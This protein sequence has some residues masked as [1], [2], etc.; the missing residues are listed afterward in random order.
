VQP[1]RD[2][3]IHLNEIGISILEYLSMGTAVTGICWLLARRR[4]SQ[5]AGSA[6]KPVWVTWGAEL[7]V[8]FALVLGGRV[9]LADWPKVPSGS[10]EPTLRVGDYLLVNK[11]AYG[12]R[13][14]FTNT[15]IELEQPQRGDVVVFRYPGDVSQLYVKRLIGLPGDVVN[16]SHGVVSINGEPFHAAVDPAP[17][18]KP[19]D[20]GQMFVHETAAGR[21]RTIKLDAQRPGAMVPPQAWMSSGAGSCQVT[22]ADAWRCTVP[23]GKYLMMGDNR[24]NSADSRV[25]GFL[26]HR[27]VYGKAVRVIVN[28]SD[29]QRLFTPL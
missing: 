14:P 5:L 24:D 28:F 3:E 18:A 4:R 25:W 27:E 17:A 9:A 23:Q 11:L 26:D 15:A 8:V 29:L 7:F 2:L 21:E 13:L 12:P 19:E 22:S 1:D 20:F 10:M 16:Y 6:R